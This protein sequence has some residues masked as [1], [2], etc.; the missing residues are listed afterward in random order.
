MFEAE[1][2]GNQDQGG[3]GHLQPENIHD[4]SKDDEER[5][6]GFHNESEVDQHL[7]NYVLSR[8]RA[9]RQIRPPSRFAN[10]DLIAFALNVADVLELEEPTS[11]SEAKRSKDWPKWKRAMEEEF[12]SL[13]KNQTWIF[14][15]RA[16]GKRVIGSEW[17]FKRKPGIPGIVAARLVAKGFSQVEGIGYHEVF[18]P[19][20]KHT[21]IRILL[22]ITAIQNLELEQLDVKT[23]FLHG[24]L[25]EKI[26][27]TRPEGLMT[28]PEG[29]V[30]EEYGGKVCLLQKSLY[31]LKQSPR[32]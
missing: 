1:V 4:M 19:D 29:F 6:E 2:T 3:E 26:L 15:D 14:V 10:A 16:K 20:F 9:R 21:S 22:A 23:A 13:V 18:S 25:E 30:K 12:Q 7:D 17:I 31:G 11:Y 5:N 8:D 24:N 32:Q 28:Q 27:M